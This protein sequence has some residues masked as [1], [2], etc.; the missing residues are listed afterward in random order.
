MLTKNDLEQIRTIV[1]DEASAVV[2][3]ELK[4]V[5]KKL[6]RVEKDLHYVIGKYDERLVAL[7]RDMKI[8]KQN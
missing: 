5:K 6:N 8:L 1:K 3:D 7:E 4:P 2:K